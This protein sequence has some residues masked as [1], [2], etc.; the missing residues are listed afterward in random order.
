[1]RI[2]VL[3]A[4]NRDFAN[5]LRKRTKRI[6]MVIRIP[7]RIHGVP[8][9][10]LIVCESGKET[11]R[12]LC[13]TAYKRFGDIYMPQMELSNFVARRVADRCL[14]SLNDL[15]HHALK[16]NESV[17]IGKIYQTNRVN[18]TFSI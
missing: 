13:E 11:I 16:D 14:L 3:N 4:I 1:M 5:N 2:F 7:V 12:W 15:V 10:F 17:E 9:K 18:V 6:A 8:D